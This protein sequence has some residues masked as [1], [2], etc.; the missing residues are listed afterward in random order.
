MCAVVN[1]LFEGF[2]KD[3]ALL[4]PIGHTG[5]DIVH[6]IP[7]FSMHVAKSDPVKGGPLSDFSF[8]GILCLAN[9][10]SRRGITVDYTTIGGYKIG[11]GRPLY[12]L[13]HTKSERLED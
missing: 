3:S 5:V 10:V 8:R 1:T 7:N 2:I 4:F 11:H 6:A 12:D 13:C 9:I